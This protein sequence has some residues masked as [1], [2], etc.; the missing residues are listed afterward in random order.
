MFLLFGCPLFRSPL[1]WVLHQNF[2]HFSPK[3]STLTREKQRTTSFS[4]NDTR[5]TMSSEN[6]V[7]MDQTFDMWSSRNWVVSV[8]SNYFYRFFI[9]SFFL[10]NYESSPDMKISSVFDKMCTIK[11]DQPLELKGR[12]VS[13][14]IWLSTTECFFSS[15]IF[16]FTFNDV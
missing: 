1:Y 9:W 5:S 3:F 15:R 8:L 11:L 6:N 13:Q 14:W 7:N 2:L 12:D 4:S 16:Y 10:E